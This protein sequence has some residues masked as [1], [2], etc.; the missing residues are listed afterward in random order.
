M[1]DT[2]IEGGVV[3]NIANTEVLPSPIHG[4]GLFATCWIPTG[5]ILCN[6]DGQLVSWDK[7]CEKPRC[8]EWNSIEHE[9]L[10]TRPYQTKYFA[11]N[12]SRSPN[13]DLD[14]KHPISVLFTLV[15]IEK[16]QEIL[17]DYRRQSLPES[18]VEGIGASYL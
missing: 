16:G 12:H 18:Y 14:S 17:L 11:I 10:L 5:I 8:S 7:H 13:V 9:L 3:D 1:N 15:S 6:L 4:M 2:G